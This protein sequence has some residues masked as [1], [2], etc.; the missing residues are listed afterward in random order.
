MVDYVANAIGVLQGIEDKFVS[1]SVGDGS[2]VVRGMA[3]SMCNA[4][5][6]IHI[7]ADKNDKKRIDTENKVKDEFTGMKT[8]LEAINLD[9]N[10]RIATR[11]ISISI[12]AK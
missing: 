9:F 8:S 5:Q 12:A 10:S 4:L 11:G 1:G 2:Q 6:A 3:A 7:L